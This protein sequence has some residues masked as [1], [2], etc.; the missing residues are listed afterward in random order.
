M[1]F[2]SEEEG[3]ATSSARSHSSVSLAC[4]RGQSIA[5][6]DQGEPGKAE[7]EKVMQWGG[8]VV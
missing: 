5:T 7:G 4:V 2:A 6:R 3:G 8:I 1:I